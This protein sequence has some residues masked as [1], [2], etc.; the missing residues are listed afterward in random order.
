MKHYRKR[1]ALLSTALTS[2]IVFSG[3]TSASAAAPA[4]KEQEKYGVVQ[5]ARTTTETLEDWKTWVNDHAYSLTSIQPETASSK[6]IPSNKFE[7]LAMLKPLLHDK[8]I[9]FLGESSHGVA[10]FNLAKTRLI[11]FLH[12]EMGYNVLAF[13]S[14]L[15]DVMNA[16]GKIDKQAALQTMKDAIF[17]V[18]WTKETLPLFEYAKTTQATEKPLFLA[19]FDIQQQGAF[20]NGDWLQN[21]QLAQQ[22]S[23]AEKQLAEWSS[24]KDLKGYQKEKTAIINVYKQV[25]AQVQT[26]EKVLQ[27]AYPNELQIVKL[28]ERTLADRIRLADE[29]VELTIQSTIEMEQNK[30]ESFLTTMEWRDQAMMENLLWLAEEVYP[31]EK[32]IVWA[33]NDHIRKAQ[34]DVMGSPYP[35]KLMGE[36]LPDIY[37]KYSYVLGLYMTSG[38]TANNMGETMPVL[39][40]IK[41][42]IEDIVS[43]ANQPY[44]FIDL[45]NR[46]NER[47][48]SWMFEPRLSYSW[49]VIQ[50]SLV[51]RDQYDGILL[52]DKVNKPTYVK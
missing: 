14:G 22:F 7:D 35:V 46:Q 31:T 9:V 29:Y 44:T 11:Q 40:P 18:W 26:K 10:Q 30:Y 25:K 4:V 43:S 39:P 16:Q 19:G 50:E 20:T 24:S 5:Q 34:S 38:E 45:R 27:K 32:F 47:G 37:K 3:I 48:N 23:D 1:K 33:H 6:K 41:G 15:G 17:G 28:M 13:E 52:I 8:R 12:Q 2:L 49:G 51:L 42:S 21:P 36:R